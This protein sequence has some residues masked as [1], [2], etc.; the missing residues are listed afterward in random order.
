[1]GKVAAVTFVDLAVALF[2]PN[3]LPGDAIAINVSEAFEGAYETI[4]AATAL[5]YAHEIHA[6]I[7][8]AS[9]VDIIRNE[10]RIIASTQYRKF[11]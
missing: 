8:N 7:P 1:M 5:T 6:R 9:V 2:K 3:V 11:P 10:Q 4:T